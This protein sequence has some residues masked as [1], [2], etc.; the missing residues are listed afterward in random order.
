MRAVSR[1]SWGVRREG[2]GLEVGAPGAT[3]GMQAAGLGAA[4]GCWARFLP[5]W[6]RHWFRGGEELSSR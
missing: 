2:A 4:R 6:R 3:E 5:D 1:A